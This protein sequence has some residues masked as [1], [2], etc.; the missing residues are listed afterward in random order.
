MSWDTAEYD[1]DLF[2]VM[3]KYN[4]SI[5]ITSSGKGQYDMEKNPVYPCKFKLENIV[6]VSAVDNTGELEYYSGYGPN[7]V[8]APGVSV[9]G[10]LPEGLNTF[11]NGTSF[12]T[13]YVTGIAALAKSISPE[14]KANHLVEI[15]H[16][17]KTTINRDGTKIEIVDAKQ[18]LEKVSS[19]Q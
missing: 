11:S 8:P 7:M 15:I 12:A 3:E 18:V 4:D 5:F 2:Q 10:V 14:F 9:L 16:D 17:S 13:A 1:K 6:C 19:Y